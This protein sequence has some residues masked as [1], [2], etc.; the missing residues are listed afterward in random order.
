MTDSHPGTPDAFVRLR[1]SGWIISLCLHG[2]A[3][4][5]ATLLASRI[6][7]APPSS[8]FHWDVTVVSPAAPPSAPSPTIEQPQVG[9]SPARV[10]TPSTPIPP[11]RSTA[12]ELQHPTKSTATSKPVIQ[13]PQTS[14]PVLPP[15]AQDIKPAPQSPLVPPLPEALEAPGVQPATEPPPTPAAH[16]PAEIQQQPAPTAPTA[17]DPEPTTQLSSPMPTV[18]Q[19]SEQTSPPASTAALAPALSTIPAPVRKADYGWL[20]GILLPRIEALKEY[21][22]DARLKHIEGRVVVRIVIQEDGQIVSATIAKSS[23]HEILDQAALETI[24]RASPLTLSQ[25]LEKASVTMQI[26]LSFN[27]AK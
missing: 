23:G 17:K 10:T 26:P 14:T 12:P 8:L 3:V 25:P 6:G 21:P 15:P 19:S 24:R 2:T 1:A 27:L 7:L 9:P 5:L 16:A 4:F 11:K 22:V 20:A 13:E 18:Q